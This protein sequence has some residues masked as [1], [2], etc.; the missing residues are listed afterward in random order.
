MDPKVQPIFAQF[1][2][3]L[4]AAPFDLP[5]L[6]D[7]FDG[8]VSSGQVAVA[9]SINNHTRD[10]LHEL[11]ERG[12]ESVGYGTLLAE[13]YRR[14]FCDLS[15]AGKYGTENIVLNVD[16]TVHFLTTTMQGVAM[17][18]ASDK[19]EQLALALEADTTRRH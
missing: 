16:M 18:T 15:Y 10:F 6:L 17:F 2:A 1:K 14:T 19:P 7:L 11:R 8:F 5:D 12:A 13:A 3:T 9:L 4:E